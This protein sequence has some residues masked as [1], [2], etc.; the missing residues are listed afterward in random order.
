MRLMGKRQIG[1][2]E[3]TDFV[4]T[5][6]ISE[7][8]SLPIENPDI[9]ITYALIPIITLV[10]FEVSSSMLLS[11]SQR[12]KNIFSSRPGFLIRDGKVD[13]KQ[14]LKNRISLDELISTLRQQSINDISE[15]KYAILEQDGQM[16]V[17]SYPQYRQ[18]TLGDLKIKAK[19][20]GISHI[21]ISN[22]SI[23]HHTLKVINKNE[24]W[25]RSQAKKQGC[26]PSEIFLMTVND[27]GNINIV[28]KE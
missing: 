11:K 19:D 24:E 10:T 26:V 16:S 13:Q 6:L 21:V 1:Q 12:F 20:T 4:T 15:V 22:G 28:K 25:V 8:A 2:L 27:A 23:N 7:I 9:P 18:P 3:V 5:L 17:I 14:L